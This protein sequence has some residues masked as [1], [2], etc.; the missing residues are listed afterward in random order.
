MQVPRYIP[1]DQ[2]V[3][4]YPISRATLTQ[5][6]ETGK[7]KAVQV[8]GL[9]AVDEEDMKTL[10]IDL[11]KDLIGI[12]IRGLDA[13][14]KYGISNVNLSRWANA[15]YIRVI[16]RRAGYLVLDEAYV[17]RVTEIFKRAKDELGSSV[18]AG[19][20]LKRAMEYFK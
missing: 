6:I 9:L 13:E 19:W 15:G 12:P 18:K 1:I 20:V 8:N 3:K 4:R 5:A 14:R 16:D 10:T 2:A 7:M 11:D 17:K